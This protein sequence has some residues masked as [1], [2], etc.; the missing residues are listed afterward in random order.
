[1]AA[2][3]VESDQVFNNQTIALGGAVFI[4]CSMDFSTKID[5]RVSACRFMDNYVKDSGPSPP[6][7]FGGGAV[8]VMVDTGANMPPISVN[9]ASDFDR[10][11]ANHGADIYLIG[12]KKMSGVDALRVTNRF[13][14]KPELGVELLPEMPLLSPGG[15]SH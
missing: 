10:N 9:I 13:S 15:V 6:W 5:Q 7:T 2:I 14:G 1:V 3:R 4:R 12:T 11:K 8:C